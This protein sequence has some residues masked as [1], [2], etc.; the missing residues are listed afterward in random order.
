[1]PLARHD[2]SH[3][4]GSIDWES[5][6]SH[7]SCEAWLWYNV[8]ESC[9]NEFLLTCL[10]RGMTPFV[11]IKSSNCLSFYSHASCEAWLVA[12]ETTSD[13]AEV[14]THMPLAR[15]DPHPT[16][17]KSCWITVSTHMPLARHDGN[18]D[19]PSDPIPVSTHMPLARHDDDILLFLKPKNVSTHMPLARHDVLTQSQF[20]FL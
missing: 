15:H 3:H 9:G 13:D 4:Q 18:Q 1:M 12:A 8:L 7:A 17:Q 19:D 14:S 20:L 6:Y 11:F 5:F 2:V 10:L 16:M